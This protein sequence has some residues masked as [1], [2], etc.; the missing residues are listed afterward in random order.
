M[1]KRKRS[2]FADVL[3]MILFP[4]VLAGAVLGVA[5][6]VSSKPRP[7]RPTTKTAA[8]VRAREI[9][10]LEQMLRNDIAQ[11]RKDGKTEAEIEQMKAKYRVDIDKL[12]A[13]DR[14]ESP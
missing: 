3:A 6:V 7:Q 14:G 2:N 13:E 10:L 9:E 12:K 8:E 4:V 5:Y 1:P 11:A